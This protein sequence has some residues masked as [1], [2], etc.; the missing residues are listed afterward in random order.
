MPWKHLVV[1]RRCRGGRFGS[2]LR[3]AMGSTDRSARRV[4]ASISLGVDCIEGKLFR[5]AL[6]R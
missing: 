1:L 5:A 3:R 6:A 2:G 4:T